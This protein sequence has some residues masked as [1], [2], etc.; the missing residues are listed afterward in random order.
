[1]TQS[2]YAI[3]KLDA[4]ARAGMKAWIDPSNLAHFIDGN[5]HFVLGIYDTTG[6]AYYPAF[7]AKRLAPIAQAPI[8]MIINYWQSGAPTPA[9]LA[10]TDAMKQF[11]MTY[12]PT[13]NNFYE[14]PGWPVGIAEE[15][16]ATAPDQLISDY[17][18]ELAS[19]QGVVGYYV[20]DEP[21]LTAQAK[22]FHQYS[23]IKASD[24]SGFDFAVINRRNDL[25]S[26]R[27][28]VDVIGVDPY[29]LEFGDAS[30]NA[31]S[32]VADWTR[33]AY[34]ATH[35][36]RPVWTVIQLF[37]GYG[38]I[39]L[40]DRAT[41]TRHELDGDR[42]GRRRPLLLVLRCSR[43]LLCQGSG[44]AC[45]ALSGTDRRNQR[46][47]VVGAGAAQSRCRGD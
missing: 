19:D 28:T 33:D 20:Q 1:M 34:Q 15:F 17:A 4:S 30:R 35:G 25:M 38:A 47:Q 8:N 37:S 40:A 26:W 46:N 12:L 5:P 42:R 29:P 43:P 45:G 11:G 14:G 23:L 31:I 9:A 21:K 27:D 2:P 41:V 6:F 16:G 36:T 32:Q 7:Y 10:Y 39:G 18:A 44:R 22:A 13:V 24:P 3:V